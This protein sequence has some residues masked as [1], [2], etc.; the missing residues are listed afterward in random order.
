MAEIGLS[1]TSVQ[2][3]AVRLTGPAETLRRTPARLT[4][5]KLADIS[6]VS[7]ERAV[8]LKLSAPKA[9]QLADSLVASLAPEPG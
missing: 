8:A 3:V 7:V 9:G 5:E 1:A 4:P 2:G 6:A